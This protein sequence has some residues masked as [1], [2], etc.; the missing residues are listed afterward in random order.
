MK[1]VTKL[2]KLCCAGF[3]SLIAII[4]I[5]R[6]CLVELS[7]RQQNLA[8]VEVLD[9]VHIIPDSYRYGAKT[10]QDRPSVHRWNARSGAKIAP[11]VLR[12]R[13]WINLYRIDFCSAP[14]TNSALKP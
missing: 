8:C 2:L 6:H 11:I 9:H 10:M 1:V 7:M 4:V 3:S 12:Y 13:K 5:A 14:D